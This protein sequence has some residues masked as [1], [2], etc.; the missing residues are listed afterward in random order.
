MAVNRASRSSLGGKVITPKVDSTMSTSGGAPGGTWRV[1][2][3]VF[4][5]V[6]GGVLKGVSGVLKWRVC[7]K[8]SQRSLSTS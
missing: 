2:E 3:G 4:E 1:R 6:I 8:A 7:K 5:G